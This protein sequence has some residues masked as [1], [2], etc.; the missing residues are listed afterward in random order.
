MADFEAKQLVRSFSNDLQKNMPDETLSRG[1]VFKEAVDEH[2][3]RKEATFRDQWNVLLNEGRHLAIRY[4][5][6]PMKIL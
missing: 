6:G 4:V 1:L 2:Q 3:T 5:I